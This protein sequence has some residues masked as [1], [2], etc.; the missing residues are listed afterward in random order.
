MKFIVEIECEN[1]AFVGDRSLEIQRILQTVIENLEYGA[2]IDY[3]YPLHDI[4]GNK[5]GK[6]EMLEDQ[7]VMGTS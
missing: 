1:A 5:V 2:D 3:N 4:N 6:A 7:Q